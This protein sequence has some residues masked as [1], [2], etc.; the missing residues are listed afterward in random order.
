M[1]ESPVSPQDRASQLSLSVA[2]GT[3]DADALP[4]GYCYDDDPKLQR[5]RRAARWLQAKAAGW[6]AAASVTPGAVRY[7]A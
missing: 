4:G 6:S 3:L 2:A 1:G 7:S 5:P